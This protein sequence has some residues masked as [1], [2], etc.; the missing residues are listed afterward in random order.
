MI[1]S[2][3]TE[4]VS[5]EAANTGSCECMYCVTVPLKSEGIIVPAV[6]SL[7]VKISPSLKINICLF[8]H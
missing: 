5:E 3:L 8:Q 2:F 7:F 6:H 1:R 4:H